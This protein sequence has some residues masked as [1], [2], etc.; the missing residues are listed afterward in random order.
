MHMQCT[1]I[2]NFFPYVTFDP[3]SIIDKLCECVCAQKRVLNLFIMCSDRVFN[4]LKTFLKLENI[5][6]V[7]FF[8]A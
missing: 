2:E 3:F 8:N 5:G 7:G 1:N 4:L 6:Y